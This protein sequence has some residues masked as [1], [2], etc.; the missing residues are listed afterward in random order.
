MK[1]TSILRQILESAEHPLNP[2]SDL[3]Q[4]HDGESVSGI[5]WL[6]PDA[7]TDVLMQGLSISLARLLLCLVGPVPSRLAAIQAGV[8]A[9]GYLLR[10]LVRVEEEFSKIEACGFKE[11]LGNRS[12]LVTEAPTMTCDEENEVKP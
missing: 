4:G 6:P 11:P 12:L 10:L 3:G 9:G 8:Q 7:S 1:T 5:T 2:L